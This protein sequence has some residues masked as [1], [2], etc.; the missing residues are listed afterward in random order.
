MSTRVWYE[1]RQP[2][3]KSRRALSMLLFEAVERDTKL[4]TDIGVFVMH[5]RQDFAAGKL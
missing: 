5:P 3:W 4:S 2:W 1:T